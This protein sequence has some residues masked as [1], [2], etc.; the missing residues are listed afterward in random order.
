M[1]DGTP[2]LST[3]STPMSAEKFECRYSKFKLGLGMFFA[4]LGF[5]VS[6]ALTQSNLAKGQIYGWLG[7]VMTGIATVKMLI[8]A[9][10]SDPAVVI[11]KEGI[12]LRRYRKLGKIPWSDVLKVDIMTVKNRN[13]S[14]K[15]FRLQLRMDMPEYQD[16][17]MPVENRYGSFGG[18]SQI[19]QSFNFLNYSLNE[20]FVA[21]EWFAPQ[22]LH[23]NL[24]L[25]HPAAPATK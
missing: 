12:F 21:V 10:D 6:L 17:S 7:V 11:D 25:G 24:L 15:F 16:I 2:S 8:E 9:L 13:G 1:L 18:Y 14:S 20:A 22:V 3:N 19:T 5:A 4:V 23:P